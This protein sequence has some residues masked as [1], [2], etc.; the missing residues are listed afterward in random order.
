[1]TPHRS[2]TV[3]R[4]FWPRPQ[5]SGAQDHG[6]A[7]IIAL[8]LMAFIILILVA[9][10]S[11]TSVEQ[12]SAQD[13][14][15]QVSARQNA[16]LSVM[17][18]IGELQRLAGPDQRATARADIFTG[19]GGVSETSMENPHWEGIWDSDI[20]NWSSLASQARLESARWLVSGNEGLKPTDPN[21]LTP[22]SDLGEDAIQ[23]EPEVENFSIP[24]ITAKKV[25]L[26]DAAGQRQ[27][28]YAYYVSGENEKALVNLRDPNDGS[29]DFEEVR[30]SFLV[31]QRNGIETLDRLGDYPINEPKLDRLAILGSDFTNW[32]DTSV[33]DEEEFRL[34]RERDLTTFSKGLLTDAKNGGLRRDLT[35]AFE[36]D[37][38]F[39]EH[40]PNQRYSS[41]TEA[42]NEAANPRSP[43]P[44]FFAEDSV[45]VS[46]AP[47][48]AVLRDYYQHY[49]D[50]VDGQEQVH[51]IRLSREEES[52]NG[53][54]QYKYL[55]YLERSGYL[56]SS[57]HSGDILPYQADRTAQIPE[58][59]GY[60][61]TSWITP[62][63][64]QIRFSHGL[65]VRSERYSGGSEVLYLTLLPVFG[66]YNPYNTGIELG[67]AGLSWQLNPKITLS[68]GYEDG[69]S[70]T[71]EFYQAE[72][73]PRGSGADFSVKFD[74]TTI[75]PG[76]T[77]LQAFDG[78]SEA[79]DGKKENLD[80][81]GKRGDKAES[82][83]LDRAWDS[84]GELGFPLNGTYPN[85]DNFGPVASTRGPVSLEDI[86]PGNDPTSDP[87]WGLTQSERDAVTKAVQEK[88]TTDVSISIAYEE[89][90]AMKLYYDSKT[91]E[92]T[93]QQT[94]DLWKPGASSPL[95]TYNNYFSSLGFASAQDSLQT[96]SLFLRTA[97]EGD[98]AVANDD[99]RNVLDTNIRAIYRDVDWD[100]DS[101]SD[102]GPFLVSYSGGVING[103][104]AAP[105]SIQASNGVQQG[106]W[107][108]S[109]GSDGDLRV[110]L[111]DRPRSP[112]LSLGQLQHANLGR[113]QFDPSYIVGNSYA[114]LRIPLSA[115]EVEDYGGVSGLKLFDWSYRVN[116][117]LWDGFFFSSLRIPDDQS[118]R[119]GIVNGLNGGSI[120]LDDVVLNPRMEF[121]DSEVQDGVRYGEIIVDDSSAQG[122]EN[123]VYRPASQMWVNGAFNVNST[124][125]E[126]WKAILGSS[127]NLRIPTY[128]ELA[129]A[130]ST[131]LETGMIYSRF[132][133]NSRGRFDSSDAS[134]APE[135]WA[136]F[137]S[138]S[139]SEVASLAEAV[140]DQ[141]KERGPFLSLASFVNRELNNTERAK[142]GA[143][144]AA[145]DQNNGLND[146]TNEDID[147]EVVV[148]FD[149]FQN[150][151]D[152]NLSAND[153]SS[154][155]FPGHLLQGDILQKLAPLLTVRSDT[156]K[157][158]A[159]G[160]VVNPINDSVTSRVWCEAVVQR[161]PDPADFAGGTITDADMDDFILPAS[162][163]GRKFKV[164]SFSWSEDNAI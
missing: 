107:G 70:E 113:Y 147:G 81:N 130:D 143:L 41:E 8:A 63:I 160:D 39:D 49:R 42:E 61:F 112:L 18:G 87:R 30:Q 127:F 162:P 145:L 57:P 158:R 53:T 144:Q 20:A 86:A 102:L 128:G 150:L 90:G 31:P 14:R 111:F 38:S 115:T 29:S 27:G 60:Q 131:S 164:V 119:D 95:A 80:P 149:E 89:S 156:F 101:P 58:Y 24:G 125:L 71:V 126:A 44:Y 151:M 64:S 133:Q 19:T 77:V 110:V 108:S 141:I 100:G 55:P 106:F 88:D 103:N 154:M 35:Q 13:K 122:F 84:V 157:I 129:D 105:Q 94:Q 32:I 5:F 62:L 25:S 96:I 85:G 72:V 66:I 109:I 93:F 138:L 4:R 98:D 52:T 3:D 43:E 68:F 23:L 26:E 1:M 16:Y 92:R 78:F 69:S 50:A 36:I 163:F 17:I 21:Y 97:D 48:W 40:F 59:D 134:T 6:F 37:A 135:Y 142:K 153:H 91:K 148:S 75:R 54:R 83:K 12:A 104:S 159:Y 121:I 140:V 33:P 65:R 74:S 139:E 136:G 152:E 114:S 22:L 2:S 137:R 73:Y 161:I 45:I 46:G 10:M 120:S 34:A 123:A 7:L 76:Q 132:E 15:Q 146:F 118:E 79:K 28:H 124:S 116:E 155:G 67:D 117:R 9:L 82:N 56:Q 99:I 51:R 11:L 47:N